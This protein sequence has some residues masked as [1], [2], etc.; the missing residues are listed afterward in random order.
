MHV[1][2][3]ENQCSLDQWNDAK[4]N[5]F[6]TTKTV[7]SDS[8]LFDDNIRKRRCHDIPLLMITLFCIFDSEGINKMTLGQ[9]EAM[10][11]DNG[12]TVF[13]NIATCANRCTEK[14]TWNWLIL[15]KFI[16]SGTWTVTWGSIIR[17]RDWTMD[18]HPHLGT[19][20][21]TGVAS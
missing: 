10:L 18:E 7:Y 1:R 15:V 2:R 17:N 13:A 5:P 12:W 19:A 14:H 20:P 21:W 3:V 9:Y 11:Q 4:A 8:F 6:R 16:F